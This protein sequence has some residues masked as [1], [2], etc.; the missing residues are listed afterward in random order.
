VRQA[1]PDGLVLVGSGITEEN[2]RRVMEHSDG[3]IIGTSLK[4]DGDVNNKVD[5]ERVRRMAE[6][7]D[8]LR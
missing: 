3:A 5:P 6:V 8:S 2:G 7:F 1:V 4:E